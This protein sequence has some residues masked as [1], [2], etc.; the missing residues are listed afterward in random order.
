MTITG[1]KCDVE[2]PSGATCGF[3][4]STCGR[5]DLANNNATL[6]MYGYTSKEAYEAGKPYLTC[7]EKSVSDISAL[8]SFGAMW[9]DAVAALIAAHYHG[10]IVETA[11]I[12]GT[13]EDTE[14]SE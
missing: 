10:G 6:A 2:L 13:I 4:L 11:V 1:I 3:W 14:P 9:Q 7:V 5:I 12:P 8:P